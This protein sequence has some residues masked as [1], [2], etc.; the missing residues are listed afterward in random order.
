MENTLSP[1]FDGIRRIGELSG[2]GVFIY[3]F[4]AHRFDYINK[5]IPEIF[6]QP[7][8]TILSSSR[9]VMQFIKAE[10]T[11]YLQS[12]FNELLEKGAITSTEFRL[13]FPDNGIKHIS[14]DAYVMEG[15]TRIVG[16]VKDVSKNKEHEDFIIRYGARKDT[17]LDMITHNLSGPLHMS[18]QL[19][20]QV[21]KRVS[22]N[23]AADISAQLSLLSDS[24]LECINIVND[25]LREEHQESAD[26]Y[27]RKTRFD[28]IE[29]INSTLEKIKELNKD[30][31]FRLATHLSNLN[32][33]ADSV[34]F[35]Q[36][37]HNLLSNAIKFTPENGRIDIAVEEAEDSF[38]ISV[39]D[40]GIGIPRHLHAL[41]FQPRTPAGR[42]G[43]KGERSSG[44]GLSIVK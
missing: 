2:D 37:I 9:I 3:N 12:R 35:F 6:V 14:C 11:Y 43:L 34:K 10:D 30:K 23:N 1:S 8:E 27:V 24:T 29:K 16:F 18:K 32:I 25:F 22:S 41:V 5:H 28:I 20:E 21:Q 19:L 36:V 44:L 4:A 31:Q 42:P 40:T 17:M 26:T 39:C 13:E 7:G 33:N 15:G 38:T